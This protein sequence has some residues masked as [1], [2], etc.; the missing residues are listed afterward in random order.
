M[1]KNE[2]IE[3]VYLIGIT[4]TYNEAE[5]VPYVMPYVERMGYDK[6]IVLDNESTDNTVELLKQYPFVEVRTYSTN[7]VF[8]DDKRSKKTLEVLQEFHSETFEEENKKIYCLTI[9]DFDEV[10]F[11]TSPHTYPF[12]AW[13]Y[14]RYAYGKE[15]FFQDT[16]INLLPPK[17]DISEDFYKNDKY[18]HL[19]EDMKCNYWTVY[20]DKTTI[21]ILNDFMTIG[22][23]NGFHKC[24]L[25]PF[26]NKEC[27]NMKNTN[28]IFGF[29]LKYID[30]NILEKKHNINKDRINYNN[31]SYRSNIEDIYDS[32]Y[33]NSFP[34]CNY[35]QNIQST[36]DIDDCKYS[37]TFDFDTKKRL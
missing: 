11:L 24:Y 30:K 12:K 31:Y 19:H 22:I 2:E 10:L 33:T 3:K 15:N 32:I 21:F 27:K 26:Q 36:R 16:M 37:G 34:L 23:T 1:N 17:R 28:E 8:D 4:C 6:F 29:H 13:I 5:M 25:K 18:V 14:N 20:G 35:F 9:T 7:G